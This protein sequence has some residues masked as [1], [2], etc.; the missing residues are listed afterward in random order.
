L[1]VYQLLEG[2]PPR[3]QRLAR[4]LIE[5][6]LEEDERPRRPRRAGRL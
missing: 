5:A 2:K 4:L 3:L 6:L 1:R